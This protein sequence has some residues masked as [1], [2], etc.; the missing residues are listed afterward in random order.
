[1]LKLGEKQKLKIVRIVSQGAYL[2]DASGSDGEGN[3]PSG[4][5]EE[6]LLPGKQIPRGAEAGDLVD[7]FIYR[8]SS[9]RLISTTAEP[10]ITLHRVERLEVKE[11]TKIGA[12]LD[13]GLE[14]DLLLPYK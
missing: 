9:D 8:D 14:R 10:L 4:R 11:V 5:P 2:A 7:V 6:V 13:M 12:F 1:M 3:T